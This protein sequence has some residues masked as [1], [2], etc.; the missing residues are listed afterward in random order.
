MIVH[1]MSFIQRHFDGHRAALDV[2]HAEASPALLCE[3]DLLFEFIHERLDVG[4]LLFVRYE[5]A[6]RR[7]RDHDI[8]QSH[9]QHRHIHLIHDMHIGAVVIQHSFSHDSILHGFRQSI[10]GTKV[11]PLTGETLHLDFIFFFYY[12]IIK[13]NLRKSL[14][15]CKQIMI[16]RKID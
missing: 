13:R 2:Q 16:I 1:G 9:R 8:M 4:A 10:P 3:H 12:R 11:L 6:F 5:N 7:C 15:L 14:I